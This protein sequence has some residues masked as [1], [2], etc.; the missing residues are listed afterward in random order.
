MSN[1]AEPTKKNVVLVGAGHTHVLVLRDFGMNPLAGARLT[2]ISRGERKPYSGM[3]PGLIAGLYRFEDIHIDVERLTR[4]AAA[5]FHN[6][7][8]VGLDLATK[9]VIRRGAGSF[10][11]SVA[12]TGHRRDTSEQSH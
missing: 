8:A 1:H 12:S 6:D 7:E 2:L 10:K 3:L 9:T 5:E 4:F 11:K